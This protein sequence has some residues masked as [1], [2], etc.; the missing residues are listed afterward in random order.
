MRT[1]LSLYHIKYYFYV[2]PLNSRVYSICLRYKKYNT[3]HYL[4]TV[5][6]IDTH[7]AK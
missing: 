6:K 5:Q 7:H 4:L 2:R 3:H 1:S